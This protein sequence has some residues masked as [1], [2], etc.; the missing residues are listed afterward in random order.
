MKVISGF[1]RTCGIIKK[2]GGFGAVDTPV[3]IPNTVVKHRRGD[4]SP[5]G[6]KIARCRAFFVVLSLNS[7]FEK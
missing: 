6:A 4:N 7:F 5:F 3:P 2:S 1:Q